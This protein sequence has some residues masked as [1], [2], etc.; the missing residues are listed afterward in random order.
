MNAQ[1]MQMPLLVS[2]IL[3]HAATYHSDQTI[4]SR[5]SAGRMHRY[6]YR[7]L[8]LRARQLAAWL[9]AIGV[10]QG[11]RVATI[12]WNTHRHLELYFA[13]AGIGAICHTLNPRLPVEQARFIVE[14]AGD[15]ALFFDPEFTALA[16]ALTATTAAIR[17]VVCL[18][19][20]RLVAGAADSTWVYET[21]LARHAPIA[22]WPTF[23]EQTAA[24]LCYTSG[25]TGRPKGVL[26]SHRSTVLHSLSCAMPNV[27]G[28]SSADTVMPVVPMFHVNAWGLP[29]T[30]PMCGAK[31]V[32]PGPALD[33]ASLCQLLNDE[34]VT[35]SAGVP[36]LWHG[37]R[38][39]LERTDARLSAVRKL[40][41]GGSALPESMIRYFE[42]VQGVP[43]L[44]GWGMTETSPVCTV[45][46]LR[47]DMQGASRDEQVKLKA[48]QGCAVFGT[49]MKIVDADGAQLP[50]DD[51]SS[52]ELLVRGHWVSREYFRLQD[53]PILQGGWF[54]TGDVAAID[55][56][57]SMRICDRSKDLIK[58][59]GEWIS[60]VELEN[61]AMSCPGVSQAAA[62]GIPDDRWGERP[63][64]VV[65]RAANTPTESAILGFLRERLPSWQVPDR[66]A[67]VER[68]PIGP[69]GKVMK[70]TLRSQFESQAIKA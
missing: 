45:S 37:L 63:L 21:E 44:Q 13:L 62:I 6:D 35:F 24:G 43:M 30:A 65:V 16:G 69:T 22:E 47:G 46:P 29:Y 64:L 56:H 33:G 19:E 28:L 15:V 38:E 58:S 42:D 48:R 50:W 17:N 10:R 8:D 54:P 49:E 25:T 23:D 52:G 7:A 61:L 53:A 66:I 3:Q 70:T 68:L 41:V 32:M 51:Q 67:F 55:P 40:V 60:S 9:L 5:L 26:Y 31:L 34:Q 39:H 1:M 20:E 27:F 14:D 11:D 12:A 2:S 59:G 18:C 4:V 36:T 57:G